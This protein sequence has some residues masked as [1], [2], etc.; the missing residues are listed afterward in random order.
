MMTA[1]YA[2]QD[3]EAVQIVTSEKEYA[4]ETTRRDVRILAFAISPYFPGAVC[5]SGCHDQPS[6]S[7]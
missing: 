1:G 4:H 2:D 3:Y 7:L 5:S 6:R